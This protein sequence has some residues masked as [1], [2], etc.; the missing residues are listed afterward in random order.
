[1]TDK[2]KE[3]GCGSSDVKLPKAEAVDL[4]NAVDYAEGAIVSRTIAENDAGTLTLFAFA[5]GQGLS[6][7]SAPFDAIVH[8]LDGEAE[9]TI[10]GKAVAAKEGQVVV[11]PADVPHAVRAPKP[12]KMLLTMLR[13]K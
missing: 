2:C 7:H 8:V 13:A 12:F 11:M 5:A 4:A 10:G 6:E 1:M 9:L 3:C